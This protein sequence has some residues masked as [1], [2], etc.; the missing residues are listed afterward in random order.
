M[1]SEVAKRYAKALY[2]LAKKNNSQEK[3][4]SEI[5]TLK[6]VFKSDA[7][8]SGFINSPLIA[9]DQKIAA[10]RATLTG[11]CSLEVTNTLML[12]AEKGR[13]D[14]FGEMVD[15]FE[16]FSDEGHGVTR[17]TVRSAS[18]LTPE[19]RL[20]I[21]ET[22]NEVTKKKVILN[23]TEDK[24]LLGGMI[25]QVGGWTFDDSLET[26]LTRLSEELNRRSH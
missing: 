16:I 9:P 2:E 3:V 12:L 20:K 19:A 7:A 25:A 5:R 1:I 21:E 10:L 15:A 26:H 23:F 11:R 14:I 24:S 22:V 4:F 6:Q 18:P 8:I 13:L 17:G